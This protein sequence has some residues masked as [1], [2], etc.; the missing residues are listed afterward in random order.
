MKKDSQLIEDLYWDGEDGFQYL[1]RIKGIDLDRTAIQEF[2]NPRHPR[3]IETP[4]FEQMD[5]LRTYDFTYEASRHKSWWLL[6]SLG[7]FYDEQWFNDV[8]MIVKGGKEASVYL[9]QANPSSDTDLLAAKVFRPR[10]LRNLRKDHIYREGRARLDSDGLEIVKD[11]QVRAMQKRTRYGQELMHTSW[12]E[13]EYLTLGKLYEAGCDVPRPYTS[14]H[15][16]ILMD[17]IG[18]SLGAAPTLNGVSLERGQAHELF[19]RVVHNLTLMLSQERVHGDLS[20]YNILYWEGAITLI[21][22][23]QAIN[24]TRN[25]NAY[26]IFQRDVV[27][28]CEY[29]ENQGVA[30]DPAKLAEDIWLKHGFS[31][32]P[33]FLW[34]EEDQEIEVEE[35]ED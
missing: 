33:N 21:D 25:P 19:E 35:A 31:T 26:A 11:R 16:A 1:P 34:E 7:P 18:D 3:V 24:P 12:I 22:F 20:A 9:C 4:L 13:H 30:T 5:N 29:F 17:F 23:P 14:G 2:K 6:D 8:L 32:A 27:R 10:S 28:I 15:N